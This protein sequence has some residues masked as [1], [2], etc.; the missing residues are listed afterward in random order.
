MDNIDIKNS[1]QIY[2]IQDLK[3]NLPQLIEEVES[4]KDVLLSREGLPMFR[5]CRIEQSVP[6]IRFGV[7]KNKVKI[8]DDFDS[9]LPDEIISEF[10]SD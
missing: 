3:N 6:R 2:N 9:P 4:G 1:T 10:M 7:L 5:I 8:S